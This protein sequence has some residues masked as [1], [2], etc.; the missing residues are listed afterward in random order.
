MAIEYKIGDFLK[1]FKRQISLDPN[2]EYKLVTISSKHRGIKLRGLKKGAL[3][4]SNMYEVKNGDFI[5]SG[6]DARNG[7]FGIIPEELDGAIVTN[8]FWYFKIDESIISKKLFLELTATTWFDEICTRGSDGTTNRVR[9]QK[10]K[11]FNQKVFLPDFKEQEMLLKHLLTFKTSRN[12]LRRELK[13]QNSLVQKLKKSILQEAIQGKLTKEWRNQNPTIEP[14]SELLKRI[15]AEKAQLIKEKKIKK[16]KPLPKISK[17]EIPY[18][19]PENWVWCRIGDISE[20]KTGNSINK[21]LKESKYQNVSDGLNY[22]GTKDVPFSMGCIKYDTGVKIPIVETENSFKIAKEKS[23]FICIEGGSSGKKIG[24]VEKDVCFGNKLLATTPYLKDISK[25]F[26]YLFYS[27]HFQI[28]FKGQSKGLRGGVSVN[29]FK[30]I[31]IPIP[32]FDELIEIV[33]KIENLM[34]K[35]QDLENEIA[36]SETNAEILMKAVLKEAFESKDSRETKVVELPKLQELESSHFPKRKMLASY[37]INQSANDDKF[38]DTKFEKLLHLADYHILKRNFGQEYKQKA[39][40]PYDNKF[41]VPFFNQTIKAGWFYKQSLGNMNRILPAKNNSKSQTTYDYFSEDELKS[42]NAL[43]ET[44]KSFDYKIP[45]IIS[46]LYAVWNNRIIK[47]QE[48]SN[49]LLKQ[50]FLDWDKGKAQYVYP[51]DRVTPAIK[52]MEENGFIPDGWGKII[53]A[54]KSKIKK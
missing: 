8:D 32:P 53:E 30:R 51:K 26:Y 21:I 31:K 54:P 42:I 46:T 25:Y 22:I 10:D 7:A 43:I 9:L 41:T 49:E 38:G 3:I 16:E 39:A 33:E 37:I 23:V 18:E 11:F 47:K 45:E 50:D 35:C 14:A 13:I 27:Y 44:F 52:W 48:I 6:I 2:R 24:Y 20:N 34:Q 15:K 28:E 5:I 19:L 1:R 4:K 40:G 12:K 17:E 29:S 36:K